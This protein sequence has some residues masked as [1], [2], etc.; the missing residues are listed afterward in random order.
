MSSDSPESYGDRSTL[1]P[2]YEQSKE[3]RDS[4]D[5]SLEVFIQDVFQNLPTTDYIAQ[6]SGSSWS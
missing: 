6:T 3:N 2:D 5:E 1:D 4:S